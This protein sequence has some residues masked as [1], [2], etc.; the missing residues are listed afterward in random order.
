MTRDMNP[1]N[2][3]TSRIGSIACM[4]VALAAREAPPAPP[5]PA[6]VVTEA[7][8]DDV[9]LFTEWVGNDRRLR[10]RAGDAPG[11][12]LS[13]ETGIRGRRVREGG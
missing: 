5:P 3:T 10:E 13:A 7:R 8:Q 4:L 9:P 12:G 11:A 2:C 1:M 6:V